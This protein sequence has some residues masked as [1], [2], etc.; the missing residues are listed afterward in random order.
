VDEVEMS[1][2]K[3]KRRTPETG[4]RDT[5][6]H[7]A[8]RTAAPPAESPA[9]APP[10]AGPPA[11][12]PRVTASPAPLPEPAAP[13]PAAAPK[14]TP[15][16]A[17]PRPTAPPV[18][19]PLALAVAPSKRAAA[20]AGDAWTL[21]AEA[22]AAFTHSIEEIAAEMSGITRSGMTAAADAAVALLGARTL[23]EAVEINAGFARRG[24]DAMIEGSAKLSEIS[25]T[26]VSAASR[27]ILSRL[28]GTWSGPGAGR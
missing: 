5:A 26:A 22:Q 12:S 23:A 19:G 21:F 8:T 7:E 15:E 16:M 3:P 1:E 2:M 20:P 9:K 14:S 13:L 11:A 25:I 6:P 17:A 10:I 24:I 18:P 28:G 27:P 4:R